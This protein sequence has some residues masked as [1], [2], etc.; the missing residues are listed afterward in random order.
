MVLTD[1]RKLYLMHSIALAWMTITIVERKDQEINIK[2]KRNEAAKVLRDRAFY[3][4]TDVLIDWYG[5]FTSIR[6]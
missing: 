5:C 4:I 2:V 3:I 1:T 6:S